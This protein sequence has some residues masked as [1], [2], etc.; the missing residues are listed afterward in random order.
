VDISATTQPLVAEGHQER[1]LIAGRYRLGSFH[2][3]DDT[4]EVWRALDEATRQVVSLEF[5]RQRDPATRERFVAGARRLESDPHQSVMRVAGIHDGAEGT[6]IVFEHLVHIPIPVGWLELA[7][8]GVA[9]A[10]K[11]PEATETSIAN[12]AAASLAIAPPAAPEAQTTQ[13]AEERPTDRGLSLLLFAL[14]TRELSLIDTNLLTDSA[15]EFLELTLAELKAVRFDPTVLSDLQS[16]VRSADL[17]A[18]ASAP[19]RALAAVGRIATIRPHL[20]LPGPRV[21]HP[22]PARAPR[23]KAVAPPKQQKV[24]V[25]AMPRAPRV[26]GWTG[27]RVRWGRVLFRGLSVGL[28]AAVLISIPPEQFGNLANIASDLTGK[29]ATVATD[30]TSAIGEKI[31]ST[32]ATPGLERASFELPPLSSYAA[33]FETQAPYPTAHPGATVEWVIALR[34]TGSVGWYRGIDG[35]QASLALA[36]GTSAGVQTTQY[37]G[38]G[39]VGWFVVHF[40]APSQP[41]VAK[42][43]LLPRIDGRGKLPDL[44]IYAT[45]TVS[46]N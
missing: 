20:R 19:V 16:F 34:N 43:Q 12:P 9:P 40:A 33:A 18:L 26:S 8:D 36:D 38:P 24:R 1:Q 42:V 3:G 35:A 41:G 39:Q 21:S 25:A 44:G 7:V 11:T 15:F 14:R 28:I 37:V 22:R 32:Q 30:V 31:A 17:S 2:R 13:A 27:P 4:T 29:V 6:F 23:V 10:V 46:Q 5:L 45:V